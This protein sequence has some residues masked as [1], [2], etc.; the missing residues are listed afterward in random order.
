MASEATGKGKATR[1][2]KARGEGLEAASRNSSVQPKL[3][4]AD[5]CVEVVFG[6]NAGI[7][8]DLLNLKG[9]MSAGE[10]SKSAALRP[11]DVHGA[12]GWL[13][14]ENKI[15][16]ARQGRRRIYSLKQ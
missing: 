16:V 7:V 5:E 6:V 10:L 15:C 9:P 14:R 8:W 2:K 12:L 3:E 11:D 13:G 4:K 1:R